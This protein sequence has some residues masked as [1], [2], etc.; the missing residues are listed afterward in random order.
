MGASWSAI[1]WAGFVAS[2]LSA[3]VFWLFRSFQLTQFSPTTQLGC[4][5]F[6]EP[7]VPLTE[8]VGFLLFLALGVSLVP[9]AYALVLAV[10]GG[11][12]WVTG[13][14]AGVVH[15][16]AAVAALPLLARASQCIREERIPAPGRFGLS[17]GQATPV[18]MVA[19]HAAYGGIVGGVVGAF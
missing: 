19:G 8:T 9:A 16:S 3:C 14:L 10:L 1:V 7:N 13:T 6:R 4:L 18:A 11:P 12:G 17:W 2:I 15:G 5:F